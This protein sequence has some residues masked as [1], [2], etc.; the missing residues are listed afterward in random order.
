MGKRGKREERAGM[1]ERDQK[2]REAVEENNQKSSC[3]F[4]TTWERRRW[5]KC[6]SKK[7]RKSREMEKKKRASDFNYDVDCWHP[8]GVRD[9]RRGRADAKRREQKI[10]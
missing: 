7:R 8:A 5:Q 9:G 10:K 3:Q 2:A 4:C 1:G 6:S